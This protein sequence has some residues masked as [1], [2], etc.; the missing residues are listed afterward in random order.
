L[1]YRSGA[2]EVTAVLLLAVLTGLGF[3][4]LG[5]TLGG[6]NLS[7]YDGPG[8]FLPAHMIHIFD[9]T[10]AGVLSLILSINCIRMWHFTMRSEHS[11]PVPLSLYVRHLLLLPIH[12]FTHKSFKEC[13]HKRPWAM[14][15]IL[16]LSYVTMLILIMLFLKDMQSGPNVNWYAHTLG[17]LSAIG[18]VTT[19]ILAVRGRIIKDEASNKHSHESDWMFLILLLFVSFTGIIQ[20]VLHR[21][22]LPMAANITYVIHLM[23]VVPMLVLE[24]PFMK[25]A[26]MAYR[27]LAIYFSQLQQAALAERAVP[28]GEP[29]KPQPVA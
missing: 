12:F 21:A 28:L 20:H 13:E 4:S 10:M 26:H 22:G 11:V 27:P 18:L 29:A 2:A 5:F 9:W 24:V 15:M 3:L 16:M 14:H 1:L 8:A 25:W 6:G 23:G 17:Y 7:V 19:S